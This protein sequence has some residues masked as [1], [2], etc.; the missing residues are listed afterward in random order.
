MTHQMV[1]VLKKVRHG[2]PYKMNSMKQG[3]YFRTIPNPDKP[4]PNRYQAS[5]VSYDLGN[6]Q[7][8]IGCRSVTAELPGG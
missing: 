5:R 2:A 7:V 6:F 3:S 1:R 4:E 8:P